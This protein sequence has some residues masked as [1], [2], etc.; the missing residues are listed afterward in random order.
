M[1]T[2]PVA[3]ELEATE[4]VGTERDER[5]RA[6]ALQLGPRRTTDAPWFNDA[7]NLAVDTLLSGGAP[8]GTGA[9]LPD[10]SPCGR[11]FFAK[12]ALD[13]LTRFVRDPFD[14]VLASDLG[15]GAAAVAATPPAAAA[16]AAVASAAAAGSSAGEDVLASAL[17]LGLRRFNR[18]LA[19]DTLLSGGGPA[20][21]G[22]SLPERSGGA[23]A[24]TGAS[25]PDRSPCG[26][27]FFATSALD[28]LTR[29]VRDPFDFVLASD[30]HLAP[31][32]GEFGC[33]SG[34]A[35]DAALPRAGD[36]AAL[37]SCF[38]VLSA[39]A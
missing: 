30:R 23:P 33:A 16:A 25:L 18:N 32:C 15:G 21:T 5:A 7:R 1:V 3:R 4:L 2:S 36:A 38:A 8:A 39:P 27:L 22:G 37:P 28:D 11:F 31:P 29:L 26:R 24:G 34:S 14:F 10:R 19:V 12:S 6:S 17:Q 20:G 35:A 9:S 13:D